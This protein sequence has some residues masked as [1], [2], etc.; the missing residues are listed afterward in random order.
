MC[1]YVIIGQHMSP[2]SAPSLIHHPPTDLVVK[3]IKTSK[4]QRL[5]QFYTVRSSLQLITETNTIRL[6]FRPTS[7][8]HRIWISLLHSP[9][10]KLYNNNNVDKSRKSSALHTTLLVIL[11]NTIICC[12]YNAPQF[13]LY[14]VKLMTSYHPQHRCLNIHIYEYLN[15]DGLLFISTSYRIA[16]AELLV[17]YMPMIVTLWC[18]LCSWNTHF[19]LFG[20]RNRM[21][22]T[23]RCLLFD[24]EARRIEYVNFEVYDYHARYH[25]KH[26][27]NSCIFISLLLFLGIVGCIAAFNRW[28]RVLESWKI[29]RYCFM[30]RYCSL[31]SR[32]RYWKMRWMRW[33][34]CLNIVLA[35]VYY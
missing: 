19:D 1:R 10:D 24:F 28:I 12:S 21:Q 6:T 9:K 17:N 33:D 18:S 14:Y 8:I 16:I 5:K 2:Q 20:S 31:S 23:Y 13:L 29:V 7:T 22:C 11:A 15:I 32:H 35:V 34:D 26:V 4:G 25:G 30:V 3:N 27:N